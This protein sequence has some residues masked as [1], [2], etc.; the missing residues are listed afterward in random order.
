MVH[1]WRVL[2]FVLIFAATTHAGEE[3]FRERVAPILEARCVYCH[4]GTKPKGGLSLVSAADLA[5]GGESGTV[6]APGRADNSLLLAYIS[7]DDPQMPQ[8]G[9]P[10]SAADVDAIREWINGGAHWPD[11]L[12]LSD[13]RQYDLDWWSLRPLLRPDVPAIAS[14]WIQT[15]IDAFILAKLSEH[16]LAPSAEADRRMLIRRLYFDLIGLPPPPDEV[17]AF[18]GDDDPHAYEKLVDRLLASPQHGERWARHWLD[19][20][21]YGDTHGYDKDKL[22]PNAWPY[23]D[24]VIRAFNDDK[25]Y[26]R[27][28]EEQVA[29]DVLYPGTPDGIIA[30]GFLVAGPFDYVGQIEVAEGTLAKAIT[31]NLDRDDIVSTVIGT[32][33]SM[34]AHCARCHNHKF[35]PIT[36]EDYYSLQAVFAG[37]D[38]A[39]REYPDA[40]AGEPLTMVFAAASE[41]KAE[42][43][44]APTHGRP[45][46]IHLLNRGNE[47]DPAVEVGPGTCSYIPSLESRFEL[48]AEAA[49]G[50]RRAALAR[51]LTDKR[52]PLTWRSIV[53]RIWQYHFGRGIVDTPN[54]FGRMGALPTHAELLEWLACEFRDGPQSIKSLHRLICTSAVYR[55]SSAGNPEFESRDGGN[56]Y[57]WRMNRRRLEAEAVRDSVLAVTGKLNLESGGPTFRAFG[58]T[59]DHS[60][61]YRYAEHDP[62]DPL[63]HRRS[64]YRLIVRSVPDPFMTTLDCADASATVAKRNETITPLQSL[65]LLNNKFMVRMS[66]HFAARI[67]PM[68]NDNVERLTAGWRLAFGREPDQNELAAMVSYADLHGMANACRLI[69]NMNEF[70]F[71][72]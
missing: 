5:K 22:R 51:W 56:Q 18:V 23:R 1:P 52:N 7:G 15:P 12:Q 57:L 16:G 48:S 26:S 9:K 64:I 25:P 71:I 20:A 68:G 65:A 8:E 31:R 30:T 44:F 34:T 36:Q 17:D 49:E 3:L 39:D 35:D 67:E 14:A 13:K 2:L 38:R 55:Q 50:E 69:F 10:L 59:D 47:K 41:F 33:N 66:E 37:I 63:S 58:F 19:V 24:Y 43:Q 32:F 54:D 4:S 27:F 29:G 72:D 62:D 53:N 6:I 60:P 11:E 70:V 21:H 61:H 42:G 28:V 45:R 40:E 46:P